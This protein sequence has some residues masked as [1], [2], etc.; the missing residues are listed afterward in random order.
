MP[1]RTVQAQGPVLKASKDVFAGTCGKAPAEV[2]ARHMSRA[3]DTPL[4]N[5]ACRWDCR[6]ISRASL[7]H[8]QSPPTDPRLCEAHLLCVSS[9]MSDPLDVRVALTGSVM[10]LVPLIVLRKQYNGKACQVCTR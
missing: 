10:Q 5:I 2:N 6:D 3:K 4:R 9:H 1:E 8:R 7:R